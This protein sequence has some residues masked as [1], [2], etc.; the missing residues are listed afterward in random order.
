M[1]AARETGS[2]PFHEAKV[3]QQVIGRMFA[4]DIG[5]WFALKQAREKVVPASGGFI[6]RARRSADP[7]KGWRIYL[8]VLHGSGFAFVSCGR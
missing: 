3:A 7:C 6:G 5:R 4:D 2:A 1:S 8:D